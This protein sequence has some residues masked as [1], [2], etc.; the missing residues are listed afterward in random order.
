VLQVCAVKAPGFGDRR[1]ALLQDLAVL[2]GGQALFEDL[3]LQLENVELS[4]L[5]TAKR[6]TI[7]K[8]NTTAALSR[9]NARS[10]PPPVTTMLRNCRNVWPSWP[11]VWHRSMLALRPKRK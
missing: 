10:R 4:Q 6:I 1:K 7:D 2:T 11:A 5:G 3:G 9:S 8:D